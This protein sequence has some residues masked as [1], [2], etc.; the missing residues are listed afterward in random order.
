MAACTRGEVSVSP[1]IERGAEGEVAR[2]ARARR[3]HAGAH[4]A[5]AERCAPPPRPSRR[6]RRSRAASRSGASRRKPS[7][8][9]SLHDP[10]VDLDLVAAQ[11]RA[12]L[13]HVG[14]D[15]APRERLLA[16]HHAAGEA[17]A[18]RDDEPARRQLLDRCRSP[19]PSSTT[20]RRFGTS[21]AVPRPMRARAVGGARQRDP[22]VAVER[23]RV[24]EPDA[25][26]AELL[27]ERRVLGCVGGRREAAREPHAQPSSFKQAAARSRA[28]TSATPRP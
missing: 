9:I 26:V 25:L 22:D 3:H 5:V 24:V 6:W 23:G 10:P 18:D 7:G 13:P 1:G 12:Q 17:G 19:R 27:G 14:L 16:H 15:A 11:Q 4:H 20:W 2:V 21:T 28:G 8:W